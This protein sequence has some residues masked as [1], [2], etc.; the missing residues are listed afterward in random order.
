MSRRRVTRCRREPSSS[1]PTR[2]KTSSGRP[3]RRSMGSRERPASSRCTRASLGRFPVVSARGARDLALCR[4]RAPR[5]DPNKR[6]TAIGRNPGFAIPGS[7]RLK[8]TRARFRLSLGHAIRETFRTRRGQTREGTIHHPA[9]VLQ[10]DTARR[11]ARC[12]RRSGWRSRRSSRRF[13]ARGRRRIR[14]R[15]SHAGAPI[16]PRGQTARSEPRAD[17]LHRVRRQHVLRQGDVGRRASGRR[18][19]AGQRVLVQMSRGAS[20]APP[21]PLSPLGSHP[22]PQ[23][24]SSARILL[25]IARLLLLFAPHAGLDRAGVLIC[26][27]AGVTPKTSVCL[28]TCDSIYRACKDEYFSEDAQHRMVPCRA[29]DTIRAKLSDWMAESGGGGKEMCEAAGYDVISAG[30]ASADGEWCFEGTP[31]ASADER[32]RR[33]VQIVRRVQVEEEGRRRKRGGGGGVRA[34]IGVDDEGVRRGG[35]RTR[36]ALRTEIPR[37]EHPTHN[38]GVRRNGRGSPPRIDRDAPP[39]SRE[40]QRCSDERRSDE[41]NVGERLD[42]YRVRCRTN[43]VVSYTK[44]SPSGRLRSGAAPLRRRRPRRTLF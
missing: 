21:P 42:A 41:R 33:R 26:D 24:I 7:H 17:V 23:P 8:S 1:A 5:V 13:R 18:T 20:L 34:V 29:S 14:R 16:S 39:S 10:S 43:R 15:V 22:P 28:H 27:R 40:T 19:H 37:E 38:A 6:G 12:E 4:V 25:L 2:T 11:R 36:R 44:I 9:G 3:S 32:E 35:D 31:P 30:R